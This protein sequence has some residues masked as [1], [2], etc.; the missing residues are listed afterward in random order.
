VLKKLFYV[1]K[2]T[3]TSSNR[4]SLVPLIL[5]LFFVMINSEAHS[6]CTSLA[7]DAPS[8][9]TIAT[10]TV[11]PAP[12]TTPNVSGPGVDACMKGAIVYL[13]WTDTS[14]NEDGFKIA[15]LVNGLVDVTLTVA[16][17]ITS[18]TDSSLITGSV[19]CY[20]IQAFNSAG[21]SS[22]SNNSCSKAGQP[23]LKM[24]MSPGMGRTMTINWSGVTTASGTDW[25]GLYAP[26]SADTDFIDW[27]Y[28]SCS[29]TPGLG[30]SSGSCSY[31]LPTSL[32]DGMYELRFF[33]NDVFLRLYT[34]GVFSLTSGGLA[35]L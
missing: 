8:G 5:C 4:L 24:A 1:V 35:N 13:T 15:R 14:D 7:P 18:Y 27:M 26:S 29:T 17:N 28:V 6:Q 20:H 11:V 16:P 9:F 3:G 33:M 22:E 32:A 23:I 19:Y 21:V 25:I 10:S 12:S 2:L 30:Q 34:T 31:V